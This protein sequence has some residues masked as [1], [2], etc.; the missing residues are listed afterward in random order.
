MKRSNRKVNLNPDIFFDQHVME[1]MSKKKYTS[2]QDNVDEFILEKGK[3]IYHQMF[4][5]FGLWEFAGFTS[6]EILK[7]QYKDKELSEYQ[8][9]S[10]KELEK[11]DFISTLKKQIQMKITKPLLI[12]KLKEK[13]KRESNYLNLRGKTYIENYENNVNS[14]YEDLVHHLLLDRISQVNISKFSLKD[15][16]R[17]V[18]LFTQIVMEEIICQRRIMGSFR[19]I[20]KIHQEIKK[21]SVQ[22][23]ELNKQSEVFN[24]IKQMTNITNRLK[25]IGDFV[26]CELVHLAFFGSKNHICHCYTT[27]EENLIKDRLIFYCIFINFFIW[28]FFEYTKLNGEPPSYIEKKYNK[29]EWRC[30]KIFILNKET[31]EKI[32]KN[33]CS[34]NI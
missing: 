28:L 5:P 2:F 6:K 16:E 9:E 11:D 7:M 17:F 26:D 15:R 18:T 32:K 27:D 21:G 33:F 29:P 12:E 1:K 34:E 19:L 3:N 20:C 31:G 30:G 22:K 14:I 8:L 24:V 23:G 4:T 13:K 10:Y 25:P